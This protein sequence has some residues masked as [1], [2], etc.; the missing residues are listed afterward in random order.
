[1]PE[2]RKLER[3]EFSN[4][5]RLM[6]ENTGELVGHL[7]DISIGGFRLECKAPILD[8]LEFLLRMDITSD[9]ADKDHLVFTARSRWCQMD[10]VDP[11]VYNVGF[12]LINI[13]P[14]DVGIFIHIFEKYGSENKNNKKNPDYLWR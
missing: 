3:R 4:Y 2:Q 13:A 8:D 14:E 12:Q 6:N 5:M 9:V 10:P 11:T 7:A 1:M